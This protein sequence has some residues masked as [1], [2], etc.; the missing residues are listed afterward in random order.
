[1]GAER[2]RAQAFLAT[3]EAAPAAATARGDAAGE[4]AAAEGQ[5]LDSKAA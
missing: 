5:G 4:T 2:R 1:V 3:F